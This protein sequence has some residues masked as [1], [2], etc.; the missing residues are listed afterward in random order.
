MNVAIWLR[1]TAQ[2]MPSA[3]AILVG[4]HVERD[5]GS[6]ARNA[7]SIGSDLA[8][9]YGVGLGDRV[10]LFLP[11]CSAYLELLYGAWFAGAAVVP[12]NAKL[13]PQEVAWIIADAGAKVLLTTD[14][15]ARELA[16]LLRPATSVAIVPVG[17]AAFID[18]Y[19]GEPLIDPLPRETNDLAWLF[20]TSGTTGRPKGA[21][22]SHGNLAAMT[23]NYFTDVDKVR[24]ED[25]A[26]Y[27][28]PMSHG[29][30]LYNFMH[31]IRGA[32]HVIPP[33]GG[34]DAPEILALVPELGSV[35]MFAAPTMV[36]RL[37]DAAK[38]SGGTG[39]GLRT[40]VYGGGPMY[41]ADIEEA[42]EVLGSRF[43]QIYGQG[44]APMTITALARDLVVDREHPRWRERLA[45]V[46]TAQSCV[47]V[48]IVN[49][50]GKTLPFGESG[51]VLVKGPVVM[52]GYWNNLE[53]T[54]DTVRDG[55]LWTG[56][57]GAMDAEGFLTLKDRS[58]D[59]IISGGSNIY[60]REIEE[61]LL[62]HP[63]VDEAAAIGRLDSEWGEITVVYVV[64]SAPVTE[65]DAWCLQHLARFKRP[66]EFIMVPELP[67]NNYGKILKTKLR[68]IDYELCR[69]RS[70]SATEEA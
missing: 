30:G 48:R 8:R 26:L 2:R 19:G 55:W 13:H 15:Q 42:V 12:I 49:E 7:G 6:F 66:K 18:L 3:A 60:P 59:V 44:E 45:S 68:E 53:A 29:A 25:A 22:L 34:F 23:L 35:S 65:L 36:R 9:R 38:Q 40:I 28:A 52:L 37:V 61:V 50:E 32:R 11:N 39:E 63:Q 54:R 5:Y 4:T 31:V 58:K 27:A 70:R 21:M 33:S 14:G 56:D 16:A 41:L 43:I 17:G 46:G 24:S 69:S 64:G 57:I 47:E 20:Y 62:R 67:K 1:R 51:E 10:A